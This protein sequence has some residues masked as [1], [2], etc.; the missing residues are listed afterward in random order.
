MIAPDKNKKNRKKG[1]EKSWPS[2]Q[3]S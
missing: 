3:S 1:D 2:Q